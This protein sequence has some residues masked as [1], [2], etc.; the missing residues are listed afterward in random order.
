MYLHLYFKMLLS[1]T[2]YLL[3]VQSFSI[4]PPD[5]VFAFRD[6]AF[7]CICKIRCMECD[8]KNTQ[9]WQWIYTTNLWCVNCTLCSLPK[10]KSAVFS[11]RNAYNRSRYTQNY[12][13]LRKV[14][15][16]KLYIIYQTYFILSWFIRADLCN[17][18][19][20]RF[21]FAMP[22]FGTIFG[23]TTFWGDILV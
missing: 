19:R 14:V 5:F 16:V 22:S 3:Y 7:M 6:L 13:W 12:L 18:I 21:S 11:V 2:K 17:E 8:K 9:M 1:E 23:K 10:L 4:T 20:V 15:F